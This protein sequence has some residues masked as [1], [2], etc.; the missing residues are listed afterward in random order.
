M[1]K[2]KPKP[3]EIEAVQFD[4]E[5]WGEMAR[6]C[7]FRIAE[8]NAEHKIQLFNK[9]GTYL[10]STDEDATGELWVEFVKAWRPV[11]VE[12]WVIK[13]DDGF[14]TMMDDEDFHENWTAVNTD[15][16]LVEIGPEAFADLE[17]TTIS[18][19]G[20]NY[21]SEEL[22]PKDPED[23]YWISADLMD[24]VYAALDLVGLDQEMQQIYLDELKKEG[25]VMRELKSEA[26]LD[27]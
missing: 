20:E 14:L 12:D 18:Y 16:N 17:L 1:A 13:F 19:R 11:H 23:Y 24:R 26:D 25:I 6:F 22:R 8:D 9:I 7:G 27:D 10:L 4:G 15:P 2:F 21:Y 5:N 3:T